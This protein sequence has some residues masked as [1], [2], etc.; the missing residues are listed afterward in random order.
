MAITQPETG[1]FWHGAR[2][3]AEYQRQQWKVTDPEKT[4]ADWFWTL[5]YIAG[6]ILWPGVSLEKKLH[7]IEAAAGMLYNWHEKLKEQARG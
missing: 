7:R 5:S 1:D 4:D 3:E 6:K 2:V